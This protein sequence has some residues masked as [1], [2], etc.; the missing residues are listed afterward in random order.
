M[1]SMWAFCWSIS[2][3]IF[4]AMSFRLPMMPPTAWRF[5]S[6]SSS[7]A[8][9]VTLKND[10]PRFVFG[11]KESPK[12]GKTRRITCWCRG[13]TAPRRSSGW[14]GHCERLKAALRRHWSL[15]RHLRPRPTCVCNESHSRW[16]TPWGQKKIKNPV[17][18][19]HCVTV[20]RTRKA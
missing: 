14:S 15:C 8:S 5:S 10:T 4:R 9:L 2:L 7:R 13:R 1:R 19:L 18:N 11:Y 6:I 17:E 16:M 20:K 12:A 3:P